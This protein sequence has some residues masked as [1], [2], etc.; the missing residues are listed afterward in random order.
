MIPA[1]TAWLREAKP[2]FNAGFSLF[3]R[4]SPN[5]TLISW[6]GRKRDAEMLR[7]ELQKLNPYLTEPAGQPA[8]QPAE[9]PAD[10]R[11]IETLTQPDEAAHVAAEPVRPA[12][13]SDPEPEPR[14]VFRTYDERRTRRADLPAELQ[15]VYD[16]VAGD[17][18]MRR[19]LHEKMKAAMSNQDRAS[20]R[21][22]IME[23]QD[24]I[25]AGWKKIDTYLNEQSS[26]KL[27]ASFNESSCRAYISKALKSPNLS[28]KRIDGVRLRVKALLEHG[29]TLSEETLQQLRQWNLC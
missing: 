4:Y 17:Y 10:I 18:K 9:Q 15:S 19:A 21:A 22:R 1:I 24:R 5:R 13:N 14:I 11:V 29:C 16:D 23:C 12:Q 20:F 28:Q 25:D 27:E 3:C 2:D 7:Y 8:E 26:R 6:I